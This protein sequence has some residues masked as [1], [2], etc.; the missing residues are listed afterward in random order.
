MYK[1]KYERMIRAIDSQIEFFEERPTWSIWKNNAPH[2]VDLLSRIVNIVN[3]YLSTPLASTK[4][5]MLKIIKELRQAEANPPLNIKITCGDYPSN[6]VA[7]L[8]KL[9]AEIEKE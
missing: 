6:V 7:Y 3:E 8:K 4:I 1:K 2:A 5:A 9:K